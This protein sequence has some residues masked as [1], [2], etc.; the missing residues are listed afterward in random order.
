M[1]EL[2]PLDQGSEVQLE[3]VPAGARQPDGV[4]HRDAAMLT[5]ELDD[6]QRKFR[7]IPGLIDG[8][9]FTHILDDKRFAGL[10]GVM[11]TPKAGAMD[12]VNMKVMRSLLPPLM[13]GPL[14]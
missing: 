3:G 13:P 8:A 12:E 2:P 1:L 7:D 9:A 6:L 14:T 10:S 11:E 5:G 4:S